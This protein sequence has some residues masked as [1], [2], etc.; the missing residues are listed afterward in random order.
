MS[1][2]L[3]SVEILQMVNNLIANIVQFIEFFGFYI[4]I[5][6][7]FFFFL[8]IIYQVGVF[9]AELMENMA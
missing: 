5:I 1:T 8:W 6:S 4:F 9:I 3:A 2:L 7:M